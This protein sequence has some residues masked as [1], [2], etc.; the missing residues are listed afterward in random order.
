VS[1]GAASRTPLRWL[2]R[3]A[4]SVSGA[5]SPAAKFAELPPKRRLDDEH[6]KQDPVRVQLAGWFGTNRHRIAGNL[7]SLPPDLRA[8]NAV[9]SAVVDRAD[10]SG[11]EK[12]TVRLI[13]RSLPDGDVLVIGRNVDE[14][15]ESRASL[16]G[17]SRL[18]WLPLCFFDL[19]SVWR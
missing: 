15:G 2:F 16:V 11:R 18:V 8:D 12:Q 7:E 9:Q 10:E 17:R 5:S 6:L 19:R 4:I 14:V 1:V 13:A 3:I